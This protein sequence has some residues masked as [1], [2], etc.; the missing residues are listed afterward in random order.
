MPKK[1]KSRRAAP[2][3]S[4]VQRQQK[5]PVRSVSPES[6][7]RRPAPDVAS[8]FAWEASLVPDPTTTAAAA[9]AGSSAVATAGESVRR[10]R[11]PSSVPMQ[12]LTFV[13]VPFASLAD[14]QPAALGFTYHF[15]TPPQGLP[16]GAELQFKG[17]RTGITAPHEKQ[18]FAVVE[19]VPPLPA[20]AGPVSITVRVTDIEPGSWT[21]QA[22]PLARRSTADPVSGL[23][24]AA[25]TGRT[26]Y[27]PVVRTRAPGVRLGAW[28]A[29]VLLGA[30]VGIA[31]E[32][33]LAGR[34]GLPV[35]R[36]T[37]LLVIACYI[38]LVGAK[39]YFLVL[40]RDRQAPGLWQTG[41]AIQGFV[42][43][44][45]GTTA[46][47]AVSWGIPLLPFLDVTSVGLL[48][49][50][51]IGRWGCFFG[52]CCTGR[53]TASRWGRWSSDRTVGV[54][55]I[56]TQPLESTLAALLAGLSAAALIG[57]WDRP[58][59]GVFV[60]ALASYTLGRQL[61]FPLRSVSRTTSSGRSWVAVLCS[62]LLLGDLA[63]V[64]VAAA[65]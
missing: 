25:G 42:L 24:L 16:L 63:V 36:T 12:E 1:R 37:L 53:P 65:A 7:A 13:S 6:S 57:G 10:Q 4:A 39:V 49:G 28:P 35:G 29:L 45:V 11:A 48:T 54:R 22:S 44:A 55:R 30:V 32:A 3:G 5:A 52:G 15:E 20:K 23:P 27:A 50:M 62:L 47:G 21:V 14:Q 60:G 41:L 46:L 59:G 64:V 38:G 58:P 8:I 56:P 31:V 34:A 26:G 51:A 2:K 43:A 61:L 17:T 9:A 40:H 33:L 18:T 19:T